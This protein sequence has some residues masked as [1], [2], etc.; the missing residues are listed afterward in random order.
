MMLGSVRE[1]FIRIPALVEEK[2]RE[3]SLVW[4]SSFPLKHSMHALC[5]RLTQTQ[6]ARHDWLTKFSKFTKPL[7]VK[8][9]RAA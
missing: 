1:Q 3:I 4:S 8:P 7:I 9:V 2:S 6:C 5:E